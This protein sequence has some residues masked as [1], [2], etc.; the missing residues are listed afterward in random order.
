M[1]AW[2]LFGLDLQIYYKNSSTAETKQKADVKTPVHSQSARQKRFGTL[3]RKWP[4]KME[5]YRP[6]GAEGAAEFYRAGFV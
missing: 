2:D 6:A 1:A 5:G 4:K 3:L